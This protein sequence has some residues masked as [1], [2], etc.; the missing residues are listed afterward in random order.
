MADKV[1]PWQRQPGEPALW[2]NRFKAYLDMG[3]DRSINGVYALL[4]DGAEQGRINMAKAPA[5]FYRMPS[6]WEWKPRAAAYD[7][8]NDEQEAKAERTRKAK[9]AAA[10]SAARIEAQALRRKIINELM[11]NTRAAIGLAELE[12]FDVATARRRLPDLI[13]LLGLLL[14]AHRL[15]YGE[16]ITDTTIT[17]T[18]TTSATAQTI[19][20]DDMAAALNAL[21][22]K[23]FPTIS[24]PILQ[25][26]T[27][28]TRQPVN[29][30]E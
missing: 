25:T 9:E 22:S 29:D 20:A 6:R 26:T 19:S 7:D 23:E 12:E 18:T 1:Q 14:K 13:N 10:E 15:E 27:T 28:I 11:G 4:R 21:K 2:Y 16:P 24:L 30:N 5:T 17:T 8:W 3:K